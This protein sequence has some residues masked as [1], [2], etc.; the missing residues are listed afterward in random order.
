MSLISST[1]IA[2]FDINIAPSTVHLI[3]YVSQSLP[4]VL[5]CNYLGLVI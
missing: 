5:F 3:G 4:L 2:V 1:G